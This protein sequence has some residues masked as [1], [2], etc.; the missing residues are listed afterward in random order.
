[1]YKVPAIA[2]ILLIVLSNCKKNAPGPDYLAL[3]CRGAWKIN[4]AQ[5]TGSGMQVLT[6]SCIR[7]NLF[8]LSPTDGRLPYGNLFQGTILCDSAEV[9]ITGFR[10]NLN[11]AGTHFQPSIFLFP[12]NTSFEY[13]IIKLTEDL[14][15]VTTEMLE[16]GINQN[17][18]ITYTH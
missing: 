8:G 9:D 18:T 2:I 1:M 13:Y 11:R 15:V 6:D 3:I 16:G 4:N 14:L 7:D 5:L 12:G 10:W 17:V